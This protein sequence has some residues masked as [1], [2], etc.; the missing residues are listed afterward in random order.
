VNAATATA[1]TMG[2]ENQSSAR[3]EV[4]GVLSDCIDDFLHLLIIEGGTRCSEL[5]KLMQFRTFLTATPGTLR[6][7]Q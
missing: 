3:R 6:F 5:E 4:W 1:A 2:N 7:T